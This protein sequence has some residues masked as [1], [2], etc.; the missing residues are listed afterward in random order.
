MRKLRQI[1]SPTI[2]LLV[3]LAPSLSMA[4]RT[5]TADQI[6]NGAQT[7]TYTVPT[8]STTLIGTTE[9]ATITNKVIDGASNTIVGLGANR[10]NL[11]T[12]GDFENATYSTN[13]TASAGSLAAGATTNILLGAKSA[14]WDA[15]ATSQT[16]TYAAITVPYGYQ[17]MNC[18]VS[19][20]FKVPSG[21][22]T[23]VL[24]AY[25]GSNTLVSG[26]ILN[27]TT[28][29][30]TTWYFPCPT[31][32]TIQWKLTSAADEPLIAIDE[33]YIGLAQNIGNVANTTD[34]TSWTPT[35][36]WSSN[37]TYTGQKWRVGDRLKGKV[38]IAISGGA[39]TSAGLTVNLP[40]ECVIDT[41]KLPAGTAT[42]QTLGDGY[43]SDATGSNYPVIVRYTST[44][45]LRLDFMD[46]AASGVV[47][48][49]Q[50]SESV[51]FAYTTSDA[52]SINFD[53]PCVGWSS[54]QAFRPEQTGW[55]VAANISGANASLG[56][57]G[58]SAYTEIIDAGLTMTPQSGSAPVAVMCST[59]NAATTPTT[60]T[61][62]CAA[63]SESLGATFNIPVA[64]TYKACA[65]F[66][67]YVDLDSGERVLTAFQ[68]I[69]TP[70]NAQTLTLEGGAKIES[71]ATALTIATGTSA[72]Q[73]NPNQ[74]CGIF[75]WSSS[76]QKGVRLMFEQ[77]ITGTPNGSQILMDASATNGQRDFFITVEPVTPTA[78]S[79]ILLG[80]ITSSQVGALRMES[81]KFGSTGTISQETGDWVNGNASVASA[82]Y[83][84]TLNSSQ[85]SSAPNCTV[86]SY[87]E[88]TDVQANVE[89]TSTSTIKVRTY[90]Q[91]GSATAA[92]FMLLCMGPK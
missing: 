10:Y 38:R 22:A 86:S 14:T 59:T 82:V 50:I 7:Q 61:S 54:E 17:G 42:T 56:V 4:A 24:S 8:A 55:Y 23:H 65:H 91:A 58:V 68:M 15:S 36:S 64:G 19:G 70:T 35:G 52:V 85:F 25:D 40:S 77:S 34:S 53:V 32:G 69:E 60:S 51:P 62:I 67:H 83:T 72:S 81:A 78:Q 45:A 57:A 31:S 28:A 20:I 49:A 46:D 39:P 74:I 27:S 12:N 44:T 1:L 79:P 26:T 87:G 13:W 30:R 2:A 92:A 89:S 47:D 9:A 48:S 84:I 11:M 21:T 18:E 43:T 5:V 29:K 33:G 16:L 88:T 63:G 3:A 66:S 80:S 71:G 6:K 76:G 37:T 73:F 41:A 90:N 75:K